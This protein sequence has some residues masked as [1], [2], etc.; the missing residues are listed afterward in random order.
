[1]QYQSKKWLGLLLAV[2]MLV[3]LLPV[4]ALAADA[5]DV[6]EEEVTTYALDGDENGDDDEGKRAEEENAGGANEENGGANDENG[7]ANDEN[8]GDVNTGDNTN[9]GDNNGAAE[10]ETVEVSFPIVKTVEVKNTGANPGTNTFN[11]FVLL[12]CPVGSEIKLSFDNTEMSYTNG[13][14]HESWG[15]KT[16]ERYY[17]LSMQVNGTGTVTKSVTITGSKEDI[18]KS[19]LEIFELPKD[20][21]TNWEYGYQFYAASLGWV[22]DF[23]DLEVSDYMEQYGKFSVED[24]PD[25]AEN[26][27]N[28]HLLSDTYAYRGY[29]GQWY[30]AYV[31]TSVSSV[32]FTNTFTGE[33]EETPDP[34][35]LYV[36]FEK[37]VAVKNEGAKPGEN[38]FEYQILVDLW[39]EDATFTFDEGDGIKEAVLTPDADGQVYTLKIT[40]DGE[41]TAKGNF[42]IKT[43]EEYG[44]ML[45]MVELDKGATNWEYDD[46]YYHVEYPTYGED[47]EPVLTVF[48]AS[49][50]ETA[51]SVSNPTLGYNGGANYTTYYYDVNGR[52]YDFA[53]VNED[54]AG[55]LS[56][57]NTFTGEAEKEET[58][59]KP[60]GNDPDDNKPDGNK[61]D[62]NK[63]SGSKPD[64][65]KTDGKP[66]GKHAPKTGD[67]ANLALWLVLA[68]VSTAAIAVVV[69]KKKVK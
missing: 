11:Y 46:T 47:E 68:T 65:S 57:T 49:P 25:G 42:V 20:D 14:E 31:S 3:S 48:S 52:W 40:V 5:A 29:D 66:S 17:N 28:G 53:E 32:A 58:P 62:G 56:F 15:G 33:A 34:V 36:P 27:K 63:P 12:D 64:S 69:S 1:M 41:G 45:E 19:Y 50:M 22:D 30:D 23:D 59:N 2:L 10:P 21:M 51:P 43:L 55:K 37:T 26:A 18:Q 9:T 7:G 13:E 6:T 38:T 8:G 16:K 44:V 67:E 54:Q 4:A 61:P 24:L 39:D 35:T 60:D